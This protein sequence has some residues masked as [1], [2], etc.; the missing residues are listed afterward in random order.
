MALFKILRGLSESLDS[1]ELHDGY[2][3]FT[4]E[5]GMFYI[6]YDPQENGSGERIPI[7]SFNRGW[8]KIEGTI[9]WSG[10][11]TSATL[12][13][14]LTSPFLQITMNFIQKGRLP[15]LQLMD[16]LGSYAY[17][18]YPYGVYMVNGNP[19]YWMFT[20]GSGNFVY[21]DIDNI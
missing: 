2:A 7:N 16:S 12:N 6:D 10:T 15:Q 5:D 11:S 1:V 20:D 13:I 4:P 14:P 18:Y 8:F 3:Y 19:N 9:S 21:C 17:V